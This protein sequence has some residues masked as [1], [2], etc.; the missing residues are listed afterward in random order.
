[1]VAT[2]TYIEA[3]IA[4]EVMQQLAELVVAQLE[5]CVAG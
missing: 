1:M 4:P 5:N 3:F 2:A